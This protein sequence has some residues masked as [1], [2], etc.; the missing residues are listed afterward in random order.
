M[1]KVFESTLWIPHLVARQAFPWQPVTNFSS[2]A[3]SL[4]TGCILASNW[5]RA[6]IFGSYERSLEALYGSKV[7]IFDKLPKTEWRGTSHLQLPE[8]LLLLLG[9]MYI[10]LIGWC[11]AVWS[12]CEANRRN[13]CQNAEEEN[14]V[15]EKIL[16]LSHKIWRKDLSMPGQSSISTCLLWSGLL[17]FDNRSGET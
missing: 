1:W 9:F 8:A 14:L 7:A 11:T 5:D 13:T 12:S 10:D 2:I 16:R 4:A 17:E 6:L 15:C 3:T